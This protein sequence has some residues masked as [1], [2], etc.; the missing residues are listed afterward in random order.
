MSLEIRILGNQ[1]IVVG[2]SLDSGRERGS[3]SGILLQIL[4]VLQQLVMLLLQ[5][6]IL[7]LLLFVKIHSLGNCDCNV[8]LC[9]HLS[10]IL[11]LFR[12]LLWFRLRL[13]DFIYWLRFF[14]FFH[15]LRLFLLGHILNLFLLFCFF[16]LGLLFLFRLLLFDGPLRLLRLSDILLCFVGLLLSLESVLC[17]FISSLFFCFGFGLFFFKL[18]VGLFLCLLNLLF[19]L[20]LVVG[21]LLLLLLEIFTLFFLFLLLLLVLFQFGCNDAIFQQFILFLFLFH[22]V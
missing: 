7:L 4:E 1:F 12:W 6:L 5:S 13:L 18:E 19:F 3:R 15:R 22:L 17:R 21:L 10:H 8:I 2:M 11:M 16:T 20:L 9:S 14:D